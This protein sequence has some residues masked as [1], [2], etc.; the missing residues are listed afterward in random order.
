MSR[1][2]SKYTGKTVERVGSVSFWDSFNGN[3]GRRGLS[4]K[5]CCSER[6]DYINV[7]REHLPLVW[8]INEYYFQRDNPSCHQSKTVKKFLNDSRF[9]V[10]EWPGNSPHLNPEKKHG[11]P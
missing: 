8:R 4:S 9:N 2:D 5:E 10:L 3:K 1:C 6:S 11:T 7:L